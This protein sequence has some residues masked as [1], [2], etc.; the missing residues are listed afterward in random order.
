[1]PLLVNLRNL[2][3]REL[4]LQG[5]LPVAELDLE[6]RDEMVQ[7]RQ[8]LRYDLEVQELNDSVL[9]RGELELTLDCQCVR[10]LKPFEY[11][12]EVADWVCH[13]PLEGDDKVSVVDDSVDLTPQIREDILLTF[14]AHPVC[15]PQ[16]GGLAGRSSGAKKKPATNAPRPAGSAWDKLDKL[17]L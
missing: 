14:P 11:R 16:C 13:L 8:P 10:C 6:L 4:A 12:L 9:A 15:D 3:R 5:E 17:K 7:A 1:M 2:A